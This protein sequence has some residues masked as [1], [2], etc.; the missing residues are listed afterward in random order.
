MEVNNPDRIDHYQ[1]RFPGCIGLPAGTYTFHI[2][3]DDGAYLF[4]N[5]QLVV[6]DMS[7]IGADSNYGPREAGG[8][9]DLQPN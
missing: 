9:I 2:T 4:I 7:K 1:V 8:T 6:G 5:D 3:S